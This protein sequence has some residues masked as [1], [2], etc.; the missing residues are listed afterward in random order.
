MS[1]LTWATQVAKSLFFDNSGTTLTSTDTESAIKEVLQKS[2]TSASPGLT[3]GRSG[4]TSSGTYLLNDTVPSNVSGR[5]V[6]VSSGAIVTAF[7]S[8]ETADTFTIEIQRR[9]G[10][11][12]TTIGTISVVN[13]RKFTIDSLNIP[14]ALNDELAVRIGTGSP[15][16]PVVGL[17]ARGTA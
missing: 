6:P 16:N 2:Q 4:N 10:N 8:C 9:V 15:K 13:S 14:V 12:F 17:I 5:L 3:W 1:I 11:T 7:V